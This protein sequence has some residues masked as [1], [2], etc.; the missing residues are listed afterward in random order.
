MK[1]FYVDGYDVICGTF[2]NTIRVFFKPTASLPFD[3]AVIFFE[4]SNRPESVGHEDPPGRRIVI[5]R[6]LSEFADYM[7]TLSTFDS[8]RAVNGYWE[9]GAPITKFA[10]FAERSGAGSAVVPI[11]K[12]TQ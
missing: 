5:T 12:V 8:G 11:H 4:A 9:G 6:P 2:K 1:D 3:C 7:V 10:V